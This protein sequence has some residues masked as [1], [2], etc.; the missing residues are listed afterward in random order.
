MRGIPSKPPPTGVLPHI[1]PRCVDGVSESVV[2]LAGSA[3]D[4]TREYEDL[5][6]QAITGGFQ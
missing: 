1:L 2:K 4:E 3:A 5:P 6:R